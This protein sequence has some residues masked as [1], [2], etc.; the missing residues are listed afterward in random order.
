MRKKRTII[1][2]KELND[3]II[4][5]AY[6]IISQLEIINDLKN[7]THISILDANAFFYQ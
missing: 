5:D 7:C 6:S 2:I 4:F 1:D 3:F